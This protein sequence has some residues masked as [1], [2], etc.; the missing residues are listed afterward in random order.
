MPTQQTRLFL[1][2]S[3]GIQAGVDLLISAILVAQI[4]KRELC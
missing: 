4:E 3:L 2:I 1:T